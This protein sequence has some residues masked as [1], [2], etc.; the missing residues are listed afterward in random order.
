MT[1]HRLLLL[2]LL[3][4]CKYST[5]LS[6][7]FYEITW[8][9][10]QVAYNALLVFY[11][12]DN[13]YIRVRYQAN[14]AYNVAEYPCKGEYRYT[15][16]GS[17]Y[18]LIN[19][20]NARIV[21]TTSKT[22][23]IGYT[24][25]NFYFTNVNAKGEFEDFYTLDDAQ[26]QKLAT[27]E[28]VNP[29]KCTWKKLDPSLFTSTY[30]YNYFDTSEPQYKQFLALARH[31]TPIATVNCKLHLIIVANTLDNSIGKGCSVDKDKLDNEFTNIAS[32]LGMPIQKYIIYGQNFKKDNVMQTLQQLNPSSNDVVIFFYRGHGF[33]WSDQ[34]SDWPLMSMRYSTLQPFES[35]A[36][37][38][39]YQTIVSKGARLNLILG[40][41]CNSDGS[42]LPSNLASNMFQAE[43][44]PNIEKLHRLF[45][46]SRGNLLSAAA[47]KGEVSWTNNYDGGFY[48]SSFLESFY[49]GISEISGNADWQKI[50]D[51]TINKAR[52]KSSYG[53]TYNGKGCSTQNGIRYVA[54]NYIP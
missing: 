41:L 4:L 11:S 15:S 26:L 48:T 46:K 51:S 7:S 3:L 2:V 1:C 54:I 40:D 12:S 8:T 18:Y 53:C 5:V 44:H 31:K 35:I 45:V 38:E 50:I 49:E 47:Q 16:T 19:G 23:Q 24:A 6:Q 21:Y 27:Q 28:R 22:N 20:E 39:V 32:A 30:L 52:Y 42:S 43:P 17:Q 36:L 25:D 10:D 14:E 29:A 34:Q 37:D 9:S 13:A 33:R